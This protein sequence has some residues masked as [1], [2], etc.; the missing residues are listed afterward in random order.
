MESRL[1][2]DVE[3]ER[4]QEKVKV[5]LQNA[6]A[7]GAQPRH[8]LSLPRHLQQHSFLRLITRA[9]NEREAKI[10]VRSIKGM[11][12]GIAYREEL[13]CI[14][15]ISPHTAVLA[16]V[17]SLLPLLY[18]PLAGPLILT[19]QPSR[20]IRSPHHRKT[21]CSRKGYSENMNTLCNVHRDSN[22]R[23]NPSTKRSL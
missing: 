7:A 8:V 17:R 14:Y 11:G 16:R 9:D 12:F 4:E 5:T 13:C 1:S 21:F 10:V 2:I 18:L 20:T 3:A 6:A 22:V 19:N 23:W 15:G